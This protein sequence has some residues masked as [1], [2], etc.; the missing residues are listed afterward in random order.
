M[1]S[2]RI[3]NG[4]NELKCNA[5]LQILFGKCIKWDEINRLYEVQVFTTKLKITLF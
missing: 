5:V 1:F 4:L 2:D 3:V